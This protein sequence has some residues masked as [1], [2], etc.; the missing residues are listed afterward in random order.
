MNVSY[1]NIVLFA[2]V[3]EKGPF[4]GKGG[5]PFSDKDKTVHGQINGFIVAENGNEI[6]W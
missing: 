1:P 6:N 2:I 3:C 4:G 5:G